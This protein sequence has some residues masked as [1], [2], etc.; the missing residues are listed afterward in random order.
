[1]SSSASRAKRDRER[2]RDEKVARK[3]ARKAEMALNP[4]E[5]ADGP[6]GPRRTE[7]EVLDE[8]AA[9]HQRFEDGQI[10]FEEFESKR[11]ELMGHLDVG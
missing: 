2:L 4:E 7:S 8:L 3:K 5:S 9:V 10:D 1:M 11:D 6:G